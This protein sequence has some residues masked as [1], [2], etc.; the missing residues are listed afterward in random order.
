MDKELDM[1]RAVLLPVIGDPYQ[2]NVWLT[3][4]DTWSSV[5]DKLYVTLN[6]EVDDDLVTYISDECEKRN[7][8]FHYIPSI[9]THG[10][11]LTQLVSV[12]QEELIMLIE[13]DNLVFDPNK[14]DELFKVAE[15]PNSVVV[16][17]RS[18]AHPE[19]LARAIAY[20]KIPTCGGE[21]NFW[22]SFFFAHKD[23]LLD[24]DQHYDS[25]DFTEAGL[26]I[27]ELDWT[28]P[29]PQGM[30]T[31]AWTS[32]QLRSKNKYTFHN[33]TPHACVLGTNPV[34]ANPL[35]HVGN[36]SGAIAH[37]KEKSRSGELWKDPIERIGLIHPPQD[38]HIKQDYARKLGWWRLCFEA[39]PIPQDN[40]AAYFNDI[41]K[42]GLDCIASQSHIS[43]NETQ[44]Y[45]ELYRPLLSKVTN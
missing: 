40:A 18:S 20:F 15:T 19:I 10:K 27:K 32:V 4:F 31:F 16:Y 29:S 24:T 12:V 2:L 34:N 1:K 41:Y 33:I 7:A 5:V 6:H 42:H 44:P 26:Y 8:T 14:I 11:A 45:T 21:P 38:A 22:P 17:R 30:D 37:H 36:A 9:G 39:F 43:E 13:M 28:T 35:I 25:K 3:N 23:I